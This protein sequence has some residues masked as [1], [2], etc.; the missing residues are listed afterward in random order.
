MMDKPLAGRHVL[1]MFV[2]GFS[3]IIAVNIALAV[4][5][6]RTFPGLE[7][8]NS[9]VASQ[10]FDARRDAQTALGWKAMV[11]YDAGTLRLR[12]AG[13]DGTEIDPTRFVATVGRPTSQTADKPLAFDGRG[14]V[15]V[16]LGTGRWRL[17]LRTR[18]AD[19]PFAQSILFEVD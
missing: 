14:E 15:R 19:E 12:I 10:S 17:D 16:A 2:G 11:T 9:Y 8:A 6:V 3:I 7:V 5:A 18:Q 4:N 1:A 13:R